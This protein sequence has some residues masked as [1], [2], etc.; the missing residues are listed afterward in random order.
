MDCCFSPINTK[1]SGS[2]VSTKKPPSILQTSIE[3]IINYKPAHW[4]STLM[5]ASYNIFSRQ[6]TITLF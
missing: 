1:A 2:I 5:I 4:Q 6:T 3:E